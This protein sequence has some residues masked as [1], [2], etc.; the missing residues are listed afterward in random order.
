MSFLSFY[1]V[2]PR[3]QTQIL[4]LGGYHFDPLSHLAEPRSLFLIHA[5]IGSHILFI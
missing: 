3:D 4:K 1:F 2:G 5:F